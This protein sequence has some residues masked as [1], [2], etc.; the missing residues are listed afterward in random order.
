MAGKLAP[1]VA[2]QPS[3]TE[4]LTGTVSNPSPLT[5]LVRST[6]IPMA[7]LGSYAPGVGDT[8][9]VLRQD[10]TWLCLGVQGPG[11]HVPIQVA[12]NGALT[13]GA[14]DTLVPGTS[15]TVTTLKPNA[16]FIVNSSWDFSVGTGGNTGIGRLYVDGVGQS[17]EAHASIVTNG[18]VTA[19]GVWS[20]L[21]FTPGQHTFGMF[22]STTAGSTISLQSIHTKY[23]LQVGET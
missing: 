3:S 19:A 2:A 9:S 8:V 11:G 7:A 1:Q 4:L 20:G 21:L 13:L 14:S 17:G 16:W 23:V 10:S 12:A 6:R 5:V 22:G 15:L 18:R